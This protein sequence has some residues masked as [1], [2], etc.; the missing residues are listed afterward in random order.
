MFEE[1]GDEQK[2]QGWTPFILDTNG[3][4]KRDDYVEPNAAGRS[5]EGQADRR[6]PL[7]GRG[8]PGRRHGLG[9][10]DRLSGRDRPR[11]AGQRSGDTALTEIYEPPLPGYGPRGGDVDTNGVYWVALA[12]GHLGELRPPQVQGAERPDRDRQALPRGLDAAPAAGPADARRQDRGQRRGQLL[13]LGRPVQHLRPRRRRA[14]RDGQPQQ[15]DLRAGQDGKF[16]DFA[17]PYPMGFFAK[18]VDGRIDDAERRL[19]G[20]RLWTDLRHAAPCS[21]W[22]AARPTGR[23]P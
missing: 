4:G 14:D 12:S 22:K 20:P 5:G 8:Q 11:R 15:R 7:R 19:E 2:S 1:T 10:G 13:R 18:N 16:I 6:Q 21:I 9:H 17:V 23:G 3:N